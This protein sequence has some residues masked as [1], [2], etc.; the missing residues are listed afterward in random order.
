MCGAAIKCYLTSFDPT[1]SPLLDAR[2]WIGSGANVAVELT[3]SGGVTVA[4]TGVATV[5]TN[6]NLTGEV[7]STGNATTIASGVVD[8]D[9]MADNAIG[10][11]EL[12]HGTDGNLYTF[13]CAGAP[14]FVAT[15]CMD[16]VLTSNGAGAAPTFQ[17][18][19]SPTH[20]LLGTTHSD[21]TTDAVTRGSLVIGNSTPAW[22]ELVVGSSG[23][24]LQSNAC[25][26]VVWAC[27]GG[28]D[29]LGNHTATC[30]LIMGTNAVTFGIDAAAP[31]GTISYHTVVAA[32]H[33]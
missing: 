6:A 32:G 25:M 17:A 31:A 10:L 9:N 19:A 12:A 8:Q 33:V 23:Q 15:G 30:C 28:C 22:D 26:D 1:G 16:Q 13:N 18:A 24:V 11:A 27:A 2:F 3:I 20:T 5:V 29:N 21:T 14:A 7:T 4:N